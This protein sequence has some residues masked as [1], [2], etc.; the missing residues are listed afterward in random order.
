MSYLY[1][2]GTRG[3]IAS[4][5]ERGWVNMARQRCTNCSASVPGAAKFCPRC[6]AEMSGG[7]GAAKASPAPVPGALPSTS[8]MPIAGI[9]FIAAAILGPTLIA[10]GAYT[11]TMALLYAGIVVAI[12]LII[13]L[14]LG[15]FF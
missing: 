3:R 7:A 14:L 9:L 5:A 10:A 8:R 6:G 4:T 11:S 15:I 1:C 12:G 13:L 2:V